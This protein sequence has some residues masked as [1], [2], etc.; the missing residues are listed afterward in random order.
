MHFIVFKWTGNRLVLKWTGNRLVLK[1]TGNRICI[2]ALAT[3]LLLAKYA[4]HPVYIL[5]AVVKVI[6]VNCLFLKLRSF[7][8]RV[9]YLENARGIDGRAL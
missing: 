6:F 8:Y 4:F 5:A 3:L 2:H 9:L 7:G 1:W